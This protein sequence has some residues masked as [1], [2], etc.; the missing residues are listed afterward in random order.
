MR[1]N[2][3]LTDAAGAVASALAEQW[4]GSQRKATSSRLTHV[5][6]GRMRSLLLICMML[7]VPVQW[8]WA[9]VATYCAHETGVAARHFGHHEHQHHAA[10]DEVSK[11]NTSV[12]PSGLDADC[13]ICHLG[14][15]HGIVPAHDLPM[16]DAGHAPPQDDPLPYGS[17]I[18]GGPERPDRLLAV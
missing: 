10:S 18:P 3:G 6:T 2:P 11:D 15:G 13:G 7:L 14:T 4:H 8:T 12:S 16:P 17:H 1:G 9:G 5:Y